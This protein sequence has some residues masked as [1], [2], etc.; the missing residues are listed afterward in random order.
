MAKAK[1]KATAFTF[2]TFN[3][4]TNR[5]TS[6]RQPVTVTRTMKEVRRG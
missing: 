2:F 6:W 3:P 4:L 1:V 5:V